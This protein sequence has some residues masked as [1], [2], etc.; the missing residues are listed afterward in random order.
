MKRLLQISILTTLATFS[1]CK[2]LVRLINQYFPPL[3]TTDQQIASIK[4]NLAL[5]DNITPHIGAFI[6]RD[7]LDKYL[8]DEIK[9]AAE[10]YSDGTLEILSFEPE[11]DFS[12]QTIVTKANFKLVLNEYHAVVKGKMLGL[13]SVSSASDSLHFRSAF[14][15]LNITDID[16]TEKPGLPEKALSKLIR[17]IVANFIENINGLLLKKPSSVHVAWKEPLKVDPKELFQSA[18]TEVVSPVSIIDRKL[19]SSCMLID[20]NGILL[21]VELGTSDL[22]PQ[23]LS[24]VTTTSSSD[25]KTLFKIFKG[26]FENQWSSAF[27][28]A[29]PNKGM[30]VN[31]K[32]SELASILN[33]SLSQVIKIKSKISSNRQPFSSTVEVEKSK[34]DCQKVRKPFTYKRYKR[35]KCDWSCLR[36]ITVGICPLCKVVSTDDPVCLTNR[37]ACNTAEEAKVAAD[38]IKYELAKTAHNVLQESEI[39]ACNVWREA[40]NFAALGKFSGYT[41]GNGDARL[42]FNKF[43]FSPDLSAIDLDYSGNIGY[44]LKS[45]IN[46]QPMDLG[47]VFLCQ[48]EYSKATNSEINIEVPK[49]QSRLSVV[50][51]NKGENLLIKANLSPIKYNASIN[52]S[53]LHEMYKDPKFLTGCSFFYTI[54]GPS[55]AAGSLSGIIDLKPE[56]ELILFGKA[57]GEYQAEEMTLTIEP[58]LFK[59]N[60]VQNKSVVKWAGKGIQFSI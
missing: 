46:I 60:G 13:T 34:I 19:K 47:Y 42:Q 54:I 51:E 49:Q 35:D 28:S 43:T 41:E 25:V 14:Q 45:E 29:A 36:T 33:E 17:P 6:G 18:S 44:K 11:L 31:I 32:K 26:K 16:F 37:A 9:K 4:Q 38:N 53:P 21:L 58:I 52:A 10:E 39:A 55:I 1:G 2:P 56:E 20:K 30:V 15:T 59:I 12:H 27:E 24:V 8:P 40:N 7:V 23:D 57:K 5:I 50:A 48:I 3:T 22:P